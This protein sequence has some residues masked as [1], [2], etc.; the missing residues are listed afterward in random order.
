MEECP[1]WLLTKQ[2]ISGGDP[3]QD[4]YED[5]IVRKIARITEMGFQQQKATFGTVYLDAKIVRIWGK[6]DADFLCF[7][8]PNTVSKPLEYD[9]TLKR[10]HLDQTAFYIHAAKEAKQ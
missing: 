8:D 3:L 7:E 1:I 9:A 5:K 4:T 6:F 10:Q 2:E